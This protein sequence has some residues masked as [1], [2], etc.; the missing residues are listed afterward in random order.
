MQKIA[1]LKLKLKAINNIHDLKDPA[2]R[3]INKALLQSLAKGAELLL[4][5]FPGSAYYQ[6]AHSVK[7]I[8]SPK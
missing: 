6:Q 1:A 4:R 8:Y 3:K 2:Y 7:R 5:K